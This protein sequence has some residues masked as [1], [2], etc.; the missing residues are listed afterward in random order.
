MSDMLYI[1]E[2][3]SLP[4]IILIVAGFVFQKIFRVEVRTFSKLTLYFMVPV[5]IFDKLY[6]TDVSWEFFLQVVPFV[7]LLEV[8]MYVLALLLSA[9]LRFN[10]SIRKAFT[11]SMVLINTGNY[12]IPLIDLVFRGDP[13]AAAS[14]IFIV[15]IQNVTTCTFGV[16]QASSGSD[17][18]KRALINMIK[19][20][21]L[22]VLLLV[23][24]VKSFNITLTG[25]VTEPMKYI[26][27]AFVAIALIGL[28]VQL[29]DV[30]L[31]RGLGRVM[32]VSAIKV[33]AAP[34]AG[35]A[36]T[37]LLDI[38]GVLGAALIIGLSTPTAVNTA[39]LALEFGNE[40]EFS[41]QVVFMTTVL[42]TFTLPLVIYFVRIY[43]GLG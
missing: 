26:S 29:A 20:P 8:C 40:Q 3:I 31:G 27:D 37:L 36:L 4:I 12:G 35:F 21:T 9:L 28:G 33:V 15:A 43:F 1:L 17:S 34:L 11:N 13:L 39:T 38:R 16:F 6:S 25:V 24:I 2:E 22:Y 19:M 41:A 10:N 14:Q 5:V 18:K 30:K 23:I 42:C 32:A 7:L